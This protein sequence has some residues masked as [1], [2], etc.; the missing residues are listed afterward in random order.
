MKKHDPILYRDGNDGSPGRYALEHEVL[1]LDL[2]NGPLFRV[3]GFWA[4]HRGWVMVPDTLLVEI[5]R[6][7]DYVVE[8]LFGYSDGIEV[9]QERD[10]MACFHK[11]SFV[12]KK[13]YN[14]LKAV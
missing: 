4:T 5:N 1:E 14:P 11:I 12:T 3:V 8:I 2:W 9:F 10:P 6:S 13:Q 7:I